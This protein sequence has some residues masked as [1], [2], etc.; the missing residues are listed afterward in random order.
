[1]K[2][3]SDDIIFSLLDNDLFIRWIID[4]SPELDAF[5]EKE[6]KANNELREGARVLK[7][8]I[9]NIKIEEPK[10][11]SDDKK[12][13]WEKIKHE[14]DPAKKKRFYQRKWLRIA[15][16]VAAV[17]LLVIGGYL[18]ISDHKIEEIDYASFI[19]NEDPVSRSENISLIL[20][21]NRTIDIDK[22]SSNV[23]YDDEGRINVDSEQIENN[24]KVDKAIINRLVV[25]Y[26]KTTTLTL[27]D[28]TKIWVNSG[29]QLIYPSV[30]TGN[31]REIYLIGEIYLD[32][33]KNE[34]SPFV[35]KTNHI[36]VN[37]LGTKLNVSAYN[38]EIEQSVV[39]VS[40]AVSVKSNE[41]KG[42]YNIL[43][44]QMFTYGAS[45]NKVNI[46]RVDVNNY[47]SWIY[48]YLLL[49]SET[50]DKVLQ[51]LE[52]HYNLHFVYNR[53][54]LGKIYVSG[55]LDLKGKIDDALRYISITA[56][57]KYTQEGDKIRIELSPN[58]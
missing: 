42:N 35:I 37:V 10:L 53:A 22:D 25:P 31:K 58:N 18:Y 12:L 9:K 20:S 49:Q 21:D 48:G 44:N 8:I 2:D 45:S 50:L 28:G 27:S 34:N 19:S 52:R 46:Q 17:A 43:P 36:D 40:G 7:N 47:I 13:I 30:F 6:I 15:S 26:G 32:V 38:D 51:K 23:V 4:P 57:I 14:I 1:M 39:L 5:W 54:D 56:P 29:S 16:S 11:T 41:L 55:K 33:T 3:Y 24:E